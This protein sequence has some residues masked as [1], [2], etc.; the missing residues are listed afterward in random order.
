MYAQT[1]R[2][3]L[4]FRLYISALGLAQITTAQPWPSIKPVRQEFEVDLARPVVI[5]LPVSSAEGPSVL[6]CFACRG[7]PEQVLDEI[8]TRD[9]V[10]WV[11]PLMCVLNSG[12]GRVSENSLLA[13]DDSP[14]WHT[15]GQFH[16][17]ELT[18]GPRKPPLLPWIRQVS[19][20]V[21]WA[22]ANPARSGRKQ[23]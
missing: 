22:A 7:G 11:G 8:G 5:D 23:R 1:V 12:S 2:R 6:Y 18:G 13:E 20:S 19:G 15:R 4:T 10:N 21:Q 14:P 9:K 3:L 16:A 17:H